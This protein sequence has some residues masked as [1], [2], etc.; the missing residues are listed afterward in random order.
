MIEAHPHNLGMSLQMVTSLTAIHFEPKTLTS[1]VFKCA[2][3][4]EA[5]VDATNYIST[6]ATTVTRARDFASIERNN[7]SSWY[8]PLEGT[9]GVKFQTLYSM[10]NTQRFILTGDGDTPFQLLYMSANTGNI[11]SS[12]GLSTLLGR[13][14][15]K[16]VLSKAFLAY[17]ANGSSLSA[18]GSNAATSGTANKFTTMNAIN[19]GYLSTQMIPYS[20]HIRSP[21]YY[22]PSRLFASEIKLLNA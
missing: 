20:G 13:V 5:G 8:S 14:S 15:V 6:G 7:F 22:Y 2:P 18:R 1:S 16:G 17:S 21:V 19:I 4:V 10:N 12:D 9:F 3:H 11:D